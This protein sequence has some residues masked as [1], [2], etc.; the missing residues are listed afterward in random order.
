[1]LKW[2]NGKVYCLSNTNSFGC[3]YLDLQWKI[4]GG[5]GVGGIRISTAL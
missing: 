3:L 4:R 1:M 2:A 5:G